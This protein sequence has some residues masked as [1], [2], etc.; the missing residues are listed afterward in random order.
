MRLEKE[1]K[2]SL[3]RNCNLQASYGQKVKFVEVG[4]ELS[5]YLN[6]RWNFGCAASSEMCQLKAVE[7]KK[8]NWNLGFQWK[9]RLVTEVFK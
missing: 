3:Q 6:K 8:R 5:S 9:A 2:L 4:K 7:M 1:E